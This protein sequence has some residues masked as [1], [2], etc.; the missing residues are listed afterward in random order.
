VYAVSIYDFKNVIVY[1]SKSSC[2]SVSI[3]TLL[4]VNYRYYV[5]DLKLIEN[6][7]LYT[8]TICSLRKH[9]YKLISPD[10]SEILIYQAKDC[11]NYIPNAT[12]KGV[13][14]LVSNER[15]SYYGWTVEK[16][17]PG[18]YLT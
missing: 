6:A 7:K 15:S 8:P 11:I 5:T 13:K 4:P 3:D 14:K 1:K 17:V 10:K 12:T 2:P 9:K 16:L 18:G